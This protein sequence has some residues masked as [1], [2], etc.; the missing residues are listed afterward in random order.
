MV[1]RRLYSPACSSAFSRLGTSHQNDRPP[2]GNSAMV[3][4]QVRLLPVPCAPVTRVRSPRFGSLSMPSSASTS[5]RI[6]R[7]IAA[8]RRLISAASSAVGALKSSGAI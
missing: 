7:V 4:A 5:L 3:S 6:R 1:R 8:L 2:P